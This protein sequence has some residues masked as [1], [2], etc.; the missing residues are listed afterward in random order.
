MIISSAT[1][2]LASSSRWLSTTSTQLSVRR[3]GDPAAPH[4]AAPHLAPQQSAPQHPAGLPVADGSVLPLE[5]RHGLQQPPTALPAGRG[6]AGGGDR[7]LGEIDTAT[8][9]FAALIA[10][11]ERLTGQKVDIIRPGD[12]GA[13]RAPAATPVQ[14]SPGGQGARPVASGPGQEITFTSTTVEVQETVVSAAASVTTADGRQLDVT[15]DVDLYREAAR[16]TSLRLTS[17]APEPKDPLVLAFSAA[18]ALTD[19]RAPVD[20]DGDGT[21]ES[22]PLLADGLA[23][24]A[25]DR[26]G[27]GTVTSGQ[28]LFGPGTGNGFA[29]LAAYDAD[30]NGW[31]DEADPVFSRLG[32]WNGGDTPMQSLAERGVG[33][34]GLANVASPF[35]LD[36]SG[37]TAGQVR[38]TGLWL[39]EEGTA[40]SVHQVDVVS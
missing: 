11:I 8:G 38:S 7:G 31:I 22:V 13:D 40:G 37:T 6:T 21:A 27:D 10:L 5:H 32:L 20:L 4:P 33:A 16:S 18:P 1:V 26:D 30:G 2:S 28:E 35:R 12:L 19:R 17:G 39:G 3:W 23:Y 9:K 25:L 36:V 34:I 14:P 15:L 24:L 29:E